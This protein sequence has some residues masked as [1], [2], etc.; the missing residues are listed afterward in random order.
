LLCLVVWSE[1][2]FELRKDGL[3]TSASSTSEIQLLNVEVKEMSRIG[4]LPIEIP[5]KVDVKIDGNK[6][7]VKGPKGELTKEFN[8]R[9]SVTVQ[10]G[11]VVVERSSDDRNDRSLHGLTRSLINGMIEGVTKGFEKKLEMVGVGY[12]AKLKGKD[13]ELE[14]GYSHPVT[15]KAVD[16]IEFEVE[17]NTQI[18]V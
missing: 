1:P 12:S 8:P 15:I 5:E 13:L 16:G 7:T 18:T 14:A 4:K 10:D 9:I 2:S 17:K 3:D 6:V 11:Q